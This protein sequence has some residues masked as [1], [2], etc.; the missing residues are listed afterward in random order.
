M[1]SA[2]QNDGSMNTPVHLAI[3]YADAPCRRILD[4]IV[5]PGDDLQRARV[6]QFLQCG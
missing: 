1:V 2:E 6:A 3:G 5:I 4:Y